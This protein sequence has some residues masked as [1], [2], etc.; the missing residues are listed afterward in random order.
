MTLDISPL[1]VRVNV[2]LCGGLSRTDMSSKSPNSNEELVGA[3]C[4]PCLAKTS[5][6]SNGCVYE[7]PTLSKNPQHV[8]DDEPDT[9]DLPHFLSSHS[10]N[11]ESFPVAPVMEPPSWAV[12]ARGEASLEVR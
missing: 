7:G 4:R 2:R 9:E 3:R 1:S 11:T 10:L 5:C 8:M 6:E 12:P